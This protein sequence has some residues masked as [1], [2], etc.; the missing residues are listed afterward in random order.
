MKKILGS[1]QKPRLSVFRSN[2]GL[3]VQLI[4]DEEGKTL[5][6]LSLKAL[7]A[8]VKGK[9]KTEAAELLGEAIAEKA[10]IKKIKKIIFDRGRERYLGRI[11]AVAEGARKG[12]LDF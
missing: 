1:A 12:G 7:Q 10:K 5:L 4:N 8:K 11:K 6:G 2:K 9:T 3:Y